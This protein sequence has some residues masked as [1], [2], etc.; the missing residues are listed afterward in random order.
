M[1]QGTIVNAEPVAFVGD[2]RRGRMREWDYES[3]V[4]TREFY[5]FFHSASEARDPGAP[6]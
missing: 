3:F 4:K 2:G 6:R 5:S 1:L